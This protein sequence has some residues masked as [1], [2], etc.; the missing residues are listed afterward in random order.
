MCVMYGGWVKNASQTA[1]VWY[2]DPVPCGIRASRRSKDDGYSKWGVPTVF[3]EQ[4]RVH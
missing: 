1:W 3:N 4:L 2:G